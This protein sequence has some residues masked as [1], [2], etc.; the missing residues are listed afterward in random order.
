MF[1]FVLFLAGGWGGGAWWKVGWASVQQYKIL[2]YPALTWAYLTYFEGF[3][4]KIHWKT[5]RMLFEVFLHEGHITEIYS[6][7]IHK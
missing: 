5:G 2:L 7:L 3:K 1:S 6:F 4:Y